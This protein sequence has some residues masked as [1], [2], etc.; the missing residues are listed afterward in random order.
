MIY[1]GKY[2]IHSYHLNARGYNT[3]FLNHYSPSLSTLPLAA[4]VVPSLSIYKLF[5]VFYSSNPVI[6]KYVLVF[7]YFFYSMGSH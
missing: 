1:K 3:E 7:Y 2:K 5:Y 6:Y 4:Q